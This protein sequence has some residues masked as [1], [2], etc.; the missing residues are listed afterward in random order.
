MEDSVFEDRGGIIFRPAIITHLLE[1]LFM[2]LNH[3]HEGKV[4]WWEGHKGLKSH[5]P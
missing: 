4:L 5:T 3:T 2:A 1:L